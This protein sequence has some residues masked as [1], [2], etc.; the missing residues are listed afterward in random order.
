MPDGDEFQAGC[1]V[2]ATDEGSVQLTAADPVESGAGRG[3][4]QIDVQALGRELR[5]HGREAFSQSCAGAEAERRSTVGGG[6][7]SGL[8]GGQDR[9]GG[10]EEPL[11]GFG[12]ADGAGRAVEEQ[13]VQL[14]FEA[15]DLLTHAGLADT[16]L[17]GGAAEVQHLG[18]G[19]EVLDL[20]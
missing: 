7:S 5:H 14:A 13:D 15:G 2:Q 11:A 12:E 4:D 9:A 18:D 6:G 1:F 8:H 10:G 17:L 19:D 20:P 16:E 3:A